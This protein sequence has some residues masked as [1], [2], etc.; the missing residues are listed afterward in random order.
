MNSYADLASAVIVTRVKNSRYLGALVEL[1]I[2]KK[3]PLGYISETRKLDSKISQ[4]NSDKLI[5]M[6]LSLGDLPK[7][8]IAEQVGQRPNR[9]VKSGAG[10]L[11]VNIAKSMGIAS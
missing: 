7:E 5:Q 10:I 4:G 3:M 9:A 2:R 6:A 11:S 1:L 8:S